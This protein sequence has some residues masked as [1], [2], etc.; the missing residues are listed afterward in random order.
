MLTVKNVLL[1][2][3]T[4][5]MCSTVISSICVQVEVKREDTKPARAQP[6]FSLT[7][8]CAAQLLLE[9]VS[10]DHPRLLS[11]WTPHAAELER[12]AASALAAT[13]ELHT[14]PCGCLP[15][16]GIP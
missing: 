11:C 3:V 2:A 1:H 13:S 7:S 14:W 8:M 10:D 9:F 4:M 12:L 15:M 6:V 16:A 5:C